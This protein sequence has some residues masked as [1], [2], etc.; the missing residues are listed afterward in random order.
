MDFCAEI[1]EDMEME[2]SAEKRNKNKNR[3][4]DDS[5]LIYPE[6][7]LIPKQGSNADKPSA[8]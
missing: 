7:N 2:K 1:P 6:I 5:L 8:Y 3:L 4:S